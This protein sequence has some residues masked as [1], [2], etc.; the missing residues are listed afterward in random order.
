AG[1]D[2]APARLDHDG[3]A[4][5]AADRGRDAAVAAERAVEARRR[6]EL[7]AVDEN[8]G[9]VGAADGSGAVLH[10]AGLVG[11]VRLRPDRDLVALAGG[12]GPWEGEG[13][14]AGHGQVRAEVREDEPRSLQALDR[15]ADREGGRRR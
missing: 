13:P 5:P 6:G 8:V 2:D 9:H 11:A 10:G 15:A 12:A 7:L 14:V 1:R 4:V 3:L